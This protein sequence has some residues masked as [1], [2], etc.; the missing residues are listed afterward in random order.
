[1]TAED[2]RFEIE[3]VYASILETHKPSVKT[4]QPVPEGVTPQT[5]HVQFL[6]ADVADLT[7]EQFRQ[8]FVDPAATS[9][10]DQ[11]LALG[12]TSFGKLTVKDRPAVAVASQGGRGINRR[13]ERQFIVHALGW[14]GKPGPE[15]VHRPVW[16]H[17]MGADVPE[18]SKGDAN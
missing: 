13:R 17:A 9:L 6:A 8:R 2:I 18:T 7:K 3:K 15:Y 16:P 4:G 1:M 11:G 12:L 14:G 5:W 10:A